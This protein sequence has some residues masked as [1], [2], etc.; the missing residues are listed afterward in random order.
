MF[1]TPPSSAPPNPSDKECDVCKVVVF[2]KSESVVCT[3]CEKT[4]HSTCV[5]VPSNIQEWFCSS[6]SEWIHTQRWQQ[7]IPDN[8]KWSCKAPF[9]DSSDLIFFFSKVIGAAKVVLDL[10]IALWTFNLYIGWAP[11]F[12]KLKNVSTFNYFDELFLICLL[13]VLKNHW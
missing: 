6:W 7:V 10:T 8:K 11:S 12:F 2:G 9:S 1:T 4:F 5:N 3:R 13:W